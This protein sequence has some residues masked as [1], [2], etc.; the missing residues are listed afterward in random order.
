M[1]KRID[2]PKPEDLPDAGAITALRPSKRVPGRVSVHVDNKSLGSVDALHAYDAGIRV[3][4]AWTPALADTFCDLVS[5]LKAKSYAINALGM[6]TLTSDQ[7][8]RSLTRR[9]HAQHIAEATVERCREVGLIDDRAAARSLVRRELIRKPAGRML[10]ESK[11][12]AKGIDRS[13]IAEVVSQALDAET[14]AGR[15]QLT[16]ATQLATKRLRLAKPPADDEQRFKLHRRVGAHLARRGFSPDTCRRA[17]E[18]AA[19]ELAD[20]DGGS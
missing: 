15:D 17:V 8:R 18:S 12:R 9:G 20:A 3:G 14:E 19:R 16:G 1:P 13:I 2:L 6:R 7:L 10:L 5:Q 11:L 4:A